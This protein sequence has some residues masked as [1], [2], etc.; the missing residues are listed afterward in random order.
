MNRLVYIDKL[1]PKK[2]SRSTWY[3]ERSEPDYFLISAY[4]FTVLDIKRILRYIKQ[5]QKLNNNYYAY[6]KVAWERLIIKITTIKEGCCPIL[7]KTNSRDHTH[8]VLYPQHREQY[9]ISLLRK[10]IKNVESRKKVALETHE[11][12]IHYP[13]GIKQEQT[14]A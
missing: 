8:A 7:Y 14:C 3:I 2:S 9:N 11:L 5:Q 10:I 1:L 4:S 12:E 6:W 13:T